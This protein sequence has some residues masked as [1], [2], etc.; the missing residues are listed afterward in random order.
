MFVVLQSPA[1]RVN[2]ETEEF[3]LPF[4]II[5]DPDQ[6][7]YKSLELPVAKDKDELHDFGSKAWEEKTAIIKASGLTH[8][9][10]EGEELQLPATFILDYEL[11]I[12][13][14][15]YGKFSS[16]NYDTDQLVKIMK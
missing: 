13:D 1:E 7:L 8:G 14:V 9:E 16:D 2:N 15:H 4:E 5:C 10:Y 12:L 11:S 3:K 6:V